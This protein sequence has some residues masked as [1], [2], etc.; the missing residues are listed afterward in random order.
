MALQVIPSKHNFVLFFIEQME[1]FIFR[2]SQTFVHSNPFILIKDLVEPKLE[3][4]SWA[5]VFL[6]P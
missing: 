2:L 1:I 3:S 5:E 4:G 6:P